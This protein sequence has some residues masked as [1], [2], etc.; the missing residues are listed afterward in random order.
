VWLPVWGMTFPESMP[1]TKGRTIYV[2]REGDVLTISLTAVSRRPGGIASRASQSPDT[3]E[4]RQ[5]ETMT[6]KEPSLHET[7]SRRLAARG[8][9]GAAGPGRARSGERRRG[10]DHPR[11][12]PGHAGRP[13]P[14]IRPGAQDVGGSRR[15]HRDRRQEQGRR[16]GVLAARCPA[17]TR[18]ESPSRSS[19]TPTRTRRRCARGSR[20][21][22]SASSTWGRTSGRTRPPS[23]RSRR[24]CPPSWPRASSSSAAPPWGSWSR[25]ASRTSWST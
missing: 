16:G 23:S 24:S 15:H 9:R 21:T 14:R 3:A 18:T 8:R 12:R 25:T 1:Q 5:G 20:A 19:S 7:S 10:R 4:A 11:Q 17:R 6:E 2:G 22:A 13:D